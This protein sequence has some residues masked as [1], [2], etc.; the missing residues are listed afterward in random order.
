M[1]KTVEEGFSAFLTWLVPAASE[2]EKASSHK[3]SVQNCLISNFECSRF[4]ETGSFGAGTGVRHYSDTDYFAVIPSK[5]LNDNSAT[6]LRHIKEKLQIKFWQTDNIAVNCPA[7]RIPFGFWASEKMEVT[8]AYYVGMA[9]Y[10][11]KKFPNYGIPNCASQWMFSSPAAHNYYVQKVDNALSNK[12]KL[13]IRLIKAWKYYCD[14]PIISFFLEIYVAR[15]CSRES[16]IDY[17]ED[18]ARIFEQLEKDNLP[19]MY[20]PVGISGHIKPCKTDSQH[21]EAL[22]KVKTAASRARRAVTQARDGK[23]D[24]AFKTYDLLFNQN[25]PA[26]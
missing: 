17:A 3:S 2:H 15:Y 13:L 20:D 11:D 5:N 24:D 26:R 23:L 18:V 14:V 25:F 9:E 4:F 10:D 7:V 22:S 6:A 12:A 1:A 19:G 8:P 21:T 16:Y